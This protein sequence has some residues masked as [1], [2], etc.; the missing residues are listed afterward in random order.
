M[1]GALVSYPSDSS[2]I[3]NFLLSFNTFPPTMTVD[4]FLLTKDLI[5]SLYHPVNYLALPQIFSEC[6]FVLHCSE[7]KVSEKCFPFSDSFLVGALDLASAVN[8]CACQIMN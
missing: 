4:D 1:D 8:G 3:S 5:I 7:S 2:S 6:I